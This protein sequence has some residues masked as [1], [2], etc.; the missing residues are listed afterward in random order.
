MEKK[1]GIEIATFEVTIFLHIKKR[2]VT[3]RVK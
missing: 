3:N 1:F 2:E